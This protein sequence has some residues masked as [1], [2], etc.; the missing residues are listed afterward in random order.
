MEKSN[1][2]II[3]DDKMYNYINVLLDIIPDLILVSFIN[4][5]VAIYHKSKQ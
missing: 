5:G 2:A 4:F 3:N 1:D